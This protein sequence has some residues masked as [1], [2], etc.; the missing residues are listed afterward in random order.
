MMTKKMLRALGTLVICANHCTLGLAQSNGGA[1][2]QSGQQGEL[3]EVVVTAQRRSQSINDVPLTVSAF[4]GDD[5]IALGITSP[6]QLPEVVPGMVYAKSDWGSPVY[7]I[8][9]VG[10]YDNSISAVP[11]VTLYVDEVPLPYSQLGEFASLDVQRV[12]VLKGPQGTLYGESSTGGTINY[13]ANKPSDTFQGGITES[14][15]RFDDATTDAFVSGPLTSTLSAR[16]AV[17]N[18]SSDGWQHSVTRPGDTLGVKDVTM[19]RLLLDWTPT[20]D[21][22]VVLNSNFGI[23][24]SQTQ[25]AQF[26]AVDPFNAAAVAGDTRFRGYPS[27]NNNAQN[28]DW[29]PGTRF[30][31]DTRQYQTALTIEDNLPDELTFT[32]ITSYVNYQ[33][34]T[35]LDADGTDLRAMPIR[36]AGEIQS[37]YQELRLRGHLPDSLRWIVGANFEN[38]QVNEFESGDPADSYIGVDTV[39]FGGFG[40]NTGAAYL[41]TKKKSV[42]ASADYELAKGLTLTTGVRYTSTDFD[43]KYCTIAGAATTAA[44]AAGADGLPAPVG[45]GQ[46]FTLTPSGLPGWW[47]TSNHENNLPWRVGIQQRLND[48]TLLYAAVT[49]GYKGGTYPDITSTT[50]YSDSFV[51]QEELLDY[52]AGFKASLFDKTLQLNGAVFYYDYKDKQVL[53]S[54]IDPKLHVP[55]NVLVNIPKSRILGSELEFLWT[56]L[57]GLTLEI[58]GTYLD[59][60]ILGNFTNIDVFGIDKNMAGESL[61]FAPTFSGFARVEYKRPINGTWSA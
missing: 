38:D 57:A 49:K 42:Y 30:R 24:R 33:P 4:K 52:E 12:E 6:D 27:F 26:L 46:C 36:D 21:L 51:H 43:Y 18:E 16:L 37:L 61:P 29:D 13:I 41:D 25:A 14:F 3:Q 40:A 28:A 58:S 2:A 23:D 15:G 20:S 55:L 54:E 56:P 39:G 53:G 34:D 8:R 31:M 9:G 1:S 35:T 44:A 5:L 10:Y 11:A 59:S 7:T 48:D 32:S 60:R 19:G 50:Y 47:Y 22:S 17:H 45:V